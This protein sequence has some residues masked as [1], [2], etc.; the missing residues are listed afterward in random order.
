MKSDFQRQELLLVN[1]PKV[2][3]DFQR[4]GLLLANFPKNEIRFFKNSCMQCMKGPK[5]ILG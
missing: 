1:F 2:K 5:V 4:Q 3:S